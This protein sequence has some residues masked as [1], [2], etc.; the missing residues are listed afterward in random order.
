MDALVL[1]HDCLLEML[2]YC[3]RHR[4]SPR[5]H[6][7]WFMALWVQSLCRYSSGFAGEMV[8]NESAVSKM[9]VFFFDRYIFRMKLST[10]FTYRHLHGFARIPCDSTAF[11]TRA[12]LDYFIQCRPQYCLIVQASHCLR[13]NSVPCCPALISRYK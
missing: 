5:G 7:L 13:I 9:R 12:T 11:V 1:R 6:G 10:G 3:Q 4:C 8:S 2:I